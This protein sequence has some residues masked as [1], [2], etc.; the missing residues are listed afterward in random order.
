MSDDRFVREARADVR[1]LSESLVSL[2]DSPDRDT[3]DGLFRT[4]HNLKGT[5][6][7]E[8]YDG[9]SALAHAL[10]DLLDAVRAGTLDP[11]REV[12][13][14]AL[15][16]TDTL[17]AMLDEIEHGGT[18]ET[19]PEPVVDSVRAVADTAA[20]DDEAGSPTDVAR[21]PPETPPEDDETDSTTEEFVTDER[22]EAALD[23]ASEFD[24]LD[25]LAADIEEP[26]IDLEDV[27]G[28]GSMDDLFDDAEDDA[29]SELE[30]EDDTEESL[31]AAL[32]DDESSFADEFLDEVPVEDT[33]G[34]PE[35][36]G[37]SSDGDQHD[38]PQSDDALTDVNPSDLDL[39]E[40]E[41]AEESLFG[42]EGT[43]S[44]GG[45]DSEETPFDTAEPPEGDAD[46][47]PGT[48]EPAD[49]AEPAA[50]AEA[51]DAAAETDSDTDLFDAET[52]SETDS[53]TGTADAEA[54]PEADADA[55]GASSTADAADGDGV[56]EA[57]AESSVSDLFAGTDEPTDA[58]PDDD[59]TADSA[60]DE[61]S[62]SDLFDSDGSDG[63]AAAEAGGDEPADVSA[64]ETTAEPSDEDSVGS[65]IDFIWAK[66]S[67][68]DEETSVDELQS[69]IE[70]ES[71]GEFDD[72]DE[73]SIQELI[74]MEADGDE[75]A[76]DTADEPTASDDGHPETDPEAET[77]VDAPT[78]AA[79][80]TPD[81]TPAEGDSAAG[82]TAEEAE[83]PFAADPFEADTA[84]ASD[85]AE[86]AD[87]PA[88]E[89][90]TT[91]TAETPEPVEGPGPTDRADATVA[92]DSPEP[93]DPADADEGI[94]TE[95]VE[96]LLNQAD[97]EM[98]ADD[99]VDA[100]DGADAPET[101]ADDGTDRPDSADAEDDETE[102]VVDVLERQ[103]SEMAADD[104]T[105][106]S[107]VDDDLGT[108][109]LDEEEL[110]EAEADAD[111]AGADDIAFESDST[112]D[113]FE[114]RFEGMFESSD[115]AT[116]G[117][118]GAAKTIAESSLP[119]GR[120]QSPDEERPRSLARSGADLQSL[121]V[122]AE[123]ADELL[124]VAERLSRHV[125]QL[126]REVEAPAAEETVSSLDTVARTLQRTVMG[127]RL[128]PL[129]RVTDRLP[130]VVRDVARE[131]GTEAEV[132]V[133]G[134][135]IQLDRGVIE[136]I[137]DP[138]VHLVR[139][140]VD[141]GIEPPAEREA[142]GKPRTGQVEVRA[143]REGDDVLI[144]VEDDGAGIDP[145]RVR[146]AAVEAGVVAESGAADLSESDVL[147]L[148]FHPGLSTREGVT[149]T[150]GRGVGMDVVKQT[151]TGLSGAVEVESDPGEGTLVRLR[152]PVSVAVA[153]VLFV[154]AGDERFAVPTA[155]V[156]HVGP[157]IGA[158]VTDGGLLETT[159]TADRTLEL[160]TTLGGSD[161]PA[162]DDAAV[163]HVD[164][165]EER[166]ELR[167][168][169]VLE[170]R[171]VVITPY[172]DL[173]ADVPELSGATT[174]SDGEL[175]HVLDTSEL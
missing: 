98:A 101:V 94:D 30:A 132:S 118:A 147:D 151:V 146:D 112:L 64:A 108:D 8:G 68:E 123:H 35:A 25:A 17:A 150:S 66:Q 119:S 62:V 39:D 9:A 83:V 14:H 135:D 21:S 175:I 139:N 133:D 164:T 152:I 32:D 107:A 137:G 93:A 57:D 153:E 5:L 104:D 114:S 166:L 127:I 19:D 43:G 42:D 144:E 145:D 4:A 38:R 67:V 16:A 100:A 131:T 110:D 37:E 174:G 79:A 121:T 40:A 59:T 63:S 154:E 53:D 115:D 47:T 82:S 163:V 143:A 134:A 138:L 157:A 96:E 20:S 155:D 49:A 50:E 56:T 140:A 28:G 90:E 171:E 167:C 102:S 148:L 33:A 105:L 168:G 10:E 173:L 136:R 22:V 169:G 46:A 60:T 141:H 149:E 86:A 51:S 2:E 6:S 75:P 156:E 129:R 1:R 27:Q 70:E 161:V 158:R 111:V 58:F 84:E 85:G 113:E 3:V 81:E 170:R 122:E 26:D 29:A 11:D 74:D 18:V 92:D 45:S 80:D 48:D 116:G 160:A 165:G 142:A 12:T 69:E 103:A 128:M 87:G 54:G 15:S 162:G 126:S 91:D 73:M 7:M 13:D 78:D 159:A 52:G 130:R 117:P 31:A 109:L 44:L 36:D 125:R 106:D 124:S 41:P 71:F 76:D 23:A 24:D 65:E 88:T 97:A 55:A 95:A 99:G 61:E 120:F 89:A 172:D 72:E 77:G 34:E